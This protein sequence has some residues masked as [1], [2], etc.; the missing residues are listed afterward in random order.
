[1]E[2]KLARPKNLRVWRIPT[3]AAQAL[4]PMDL[5]RSI[6]PFVSSSWLSM[7]MPLSL[8]VRVRI[9]TISQARWLLSCFAFAFSRISQ[10]L[11]S[12]SSEWNFK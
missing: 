1:M 2:N 6:R 10:E 7:G 5:I 12:Y 8:T 4:I 11:N 3:A 9:R